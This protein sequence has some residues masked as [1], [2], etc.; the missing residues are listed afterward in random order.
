MKKPG[1]IFAFVAFYSITA[2]AWWTV[3]HIRSSHQLLLEKE[4]NLEY[5]CYKAT[6]ET[7]GA[8]GQ[9]LFN[10]TN[11]VRNFLAVNFPDL[12]IIFLEPEK[13]LIPFDQFLIRP[14]QDAFLK[15]KKKY[16]RS[17]WMYSLEGAVM[18]I[19]LMWGI[20]WIYRS[21][22]NRLK[23][24]KHQ[25]NFMLSITHELKTPLASV[26]LYLETLLKRDL[27]KEQTSTILRNSLKELVR[28]KDLVNNILMAAQLENKKFELYKTEINL[29][30]VVEK[31]IHK[32][33]TPRDIYHRFELSLDENIFIEGDAI[34][35]E[36]IVANLISNAVKY[37]P[38]EGK[39]RVTVSQ[40]DRGVLF[41]VTDEGPG[42]SEADKGELFKKFYR[43][44]DEQTRKT[45]GTGLGLFIVK[46]LLNLMQARIEVK[47]NFPKG[48]TFE[49][50][51]RHYNGE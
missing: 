43:S 15:L 34:A 32:F 29:S 18:V 1:V 37:S 33:A 46:N 50:I 49:I 22:Q 42:I 11:D 17:I 12:E 26:K 14:S 48:T 31:T 19:L 30:D 28:L 8:I 6:L 20:V 40:K 25:N 4:K 13:Q 27:D 10:D 3:A 51:F 7:N 36:V 35:T 38:E 2:F 47:D 41:A 45:T 44:G 39:I 23:F 9:E 21:L 24:N 16:D 5:Q